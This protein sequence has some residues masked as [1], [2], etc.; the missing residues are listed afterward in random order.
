VSP[1]AQ[2]I[3]EVPTFYSRV[4]VANP[5]GLIRAGME[6]RG[7][8]RTGWRPSGYVFFRRVFIWLYSKLWYWIG[9]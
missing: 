1:K 8:I 9:W 6:G 3:H 4:A 7:K 2:V 5:D